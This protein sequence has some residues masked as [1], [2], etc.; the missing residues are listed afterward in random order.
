MAVLFLIVLID[1][2]GFGIIIPLLPFYGERFGA[3]PF[4][5]GLLMAIY[6]FCQLLAAPLWGRLS[7]RIGRRPVLLLGMAGAA[8]SYLWLASADSLWTLYAAR[9]LGGAM[10]GNI[11]AAFAYV[12]DVTTPA[13]RAKGM[14]VVGAA[15]S[16]GF[17]AGPAVGGLLAGADPA[18]ANFHLPSLVA[19]GMSICAIGMGLVWLKE[20]RPPGANTDQPGRGGVPIPDLLR[21][22]AL[23]M[24]LAASFLAI[25]VFAGIE[26]TFALWSVRRFGWGPEQ[27]GYLFAFVGLLSAA[28]Q[29]GAIGILSRRLG[30]PRM[31]VWGAVLLAAGIAA[32]PFTGQVA[33][34]VFV[35]AVVAIGFSMLS[36]PLNSQIS[37]Q[38]DES[39]QGA[40]MGLAR[41]ATTLA[42]VVGPAWAGYLF[43]VGGMDW[44]FLAGACVMVV[45][46]PLAFA[47]CRSAATSDKPTA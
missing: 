8:I 46:V 33:S 13:N 32:V 12:A 27:N 40:I 25:F 42:R 22:P 20:S 24:L 9:A 43:S 18:T 35:M 10:A 1:L 3:D 45:V 29:G 31:I 14:G 38:A 30:E 4:E 37:R 47:A 41:S 23:P 19:A 15:F 5:V 2:I 7:D 34:L 11:A 16:L 36:P 39:R 17:I 21:R 44:P 6:S 26:A 28:I